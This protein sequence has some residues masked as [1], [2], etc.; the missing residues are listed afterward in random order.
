MYTSISE[1]FRFLACCYVRGKFLR[2]C[3][4]HHGV[5]EDE[6]EEE[7]EEEEEQNSEFT[8]ATS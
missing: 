6:E 2:G 4:K 7:E 3:A 8:C 1:R 5:F